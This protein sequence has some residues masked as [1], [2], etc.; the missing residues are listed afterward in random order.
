MSLQFAD[1]GGWIAARVADQVAA[2]PERSF[3][4]VRDVHGSRTAV[5]A[6]S[7]SR[8]EIRRALQVPSTI[9]R[10]ERGRAGPLD[11]PPAV[12][13]GV[14]VP[15]AERALT[16]AFGEF[17]PVILSPGPGRSL[18]HMRE[19]ELGTGRPDAVLVAVSRAGLEARLKKGLRL[20]SLAHARVLESSRTGAPSGYS[21]RYSSQLM[22]SLHELGWLT[23]RGRVRASTSLVASSL[24]VEAK[25]SD[26]HRGIGQ[27][28]KARWASHDGALL[29][30]ME[31]QH[32]V[33]RAALRHNR[34][35]LLVARP[36][37]VDW[38]VRSKR[39]ELRRTADLW[40]TEL[41]I[42]SL[43]ADRS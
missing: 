22:K 39:V 24:V 3:V 20:P 18:I 1:M 29:M 7:S 17:A 31:N 43:E 37:I 25:V 36:D 30:P 2:L 23:R 8:A 38:R 14:G 13:A 16:E 35:G 34:L 33:S 6:T 40:L 21:R 11:A 10:R 26:W 12:T 41:A 5:D 15:V 32:R 4:A 19:V 42:R 27:L 28:A 9:P